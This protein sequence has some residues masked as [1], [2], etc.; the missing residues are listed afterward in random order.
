MDGWMG[1]WMDEQTDEVYRQIQI[2]RQ[3]DHDRSI[4]IAAAW[5]YY[6]RLYQVHGDG[7]PSGKLT[8]LLKI[9]IYG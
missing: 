7:V 2:G 3:V 6:S 9:A 1:G 5:I 8:E 4:S